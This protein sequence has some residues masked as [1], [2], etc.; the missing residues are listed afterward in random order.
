[1]DQP[2]FADLSALGVESRI[3][4][5]VLTLIFWALKTSY[6]QST[7]PQSPLHPRPST[8][9]FHLTP[10]TA[11]KRHIFPCSTSSELNIPT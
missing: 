4:V 5:V 11:G 10:S 9:M 2:G 6:A 7:T 3:G 1:M 8:L